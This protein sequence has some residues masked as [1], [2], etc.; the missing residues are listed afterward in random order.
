MAASLTPQRDR[1]RLTIK[2]AL[3]EERPA[4]AS[5]AKN[6][7]LNKHSSVKATGASVSVARQNR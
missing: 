4:A 6:D 1:V 3:N 7:Q 5:S 2:K